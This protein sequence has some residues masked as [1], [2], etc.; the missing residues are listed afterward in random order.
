[1][2]IE[3]VVRDG[4]RESRTREEGRTRLQTNGL[5]AQRQLL[6][7]RDGTTTFEG[8][9]SFISWS[10]ASFKAV[11]NRVQECL[12]TTASAT[13]SRLSDINYRV[14]KV[15][16]WFRGCKAFRHGYL[17]IVLQG[18]PVVLAKRFSQ[19]TF[20]FFRS[21]NQPKADGTHAES[22]GCWHAGRISKV[23]ILDLGR[24]LGQI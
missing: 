18:R 6:H 17:A 13:K 1:M 7:Q 24:A 23:P 15:R 8:G 10:A 3:P 2:H 12:L 22:G 20:Q 14:E 4:S 11:A 21:L 16:N 19:V 9:S 5:P